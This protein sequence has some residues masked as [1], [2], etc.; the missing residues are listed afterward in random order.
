M[1]EGEI[2]YIALNDFSNEEI[3]TAFRK[4]LPQ[5]AKAKG[6]IIDLR[7]NGGGD[8][9]NSSAIVG[10]FAETPFKGA[11]WRTPVHYGVYKAWGM[12]ADS[13]E[14]L[15][16]YRD[17]YF[18]HVYHTEKATEYQP[19]DG[20]KLTEPTVVLI[21]RKTA[22]AAEDFLIMADGI[23]H[24]TYIGEPT[25]GSTGQPLM[26]DLPGGGSARISTKRDFYP[27]GKE[28]IGL[29]VEPDLEVKPTVESFLSGEDQVLEKAIASLIEGSAD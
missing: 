27:D 26:M 3:V 23:D 11:A 22:S 17:Y 21:G 7:R 2:A 18:G 25:F 10:H 1:L 19:S 9:R 14:E 29:G 6:I 28:F 15:E 20:I 4:K 13:I 12:Y 8:S 24:I 5:M 16:K